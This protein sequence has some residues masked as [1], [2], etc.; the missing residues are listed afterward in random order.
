MAAPS[1]TRM[2]RPASLPWFER[3]CQMPTTER[4]APR[5]GGSPPGG[6][7]AAATTTALRTHVASLMTERRSL[8]RFIQAAP[9]A[10]DFLQFDPDPGAGGDRLTVTQLGS[11]QVL[12]RQP[13]GAED[14]D[15]VVAL[16]PLL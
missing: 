16:A 7:T 5:H 9:R 10:A 12:P 14:G 2:M 1:C 3:H 4:G 6:V 13:D 8:A 15:L 11:D